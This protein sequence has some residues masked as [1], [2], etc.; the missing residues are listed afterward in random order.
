MS[1]LVRLLRVKAI[2]L[3]SLFIFIEVWLKHRL[4]VHSSSEQGKFISKGLEL[5]F[6]ARQKLLSAH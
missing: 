2:G 1:M 3:V 4:S 5:Q 6:L